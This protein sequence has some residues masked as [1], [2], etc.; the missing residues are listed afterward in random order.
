MA[1]RKFRWSKK[2]TLT[3]IGIA[4]IFLTLIIVL[5]FNLSAQEL[6]VSIIASNL[7]IVLIIIT[8]LT[9]QAKIDVKAIWGKKND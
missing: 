9:G 4:S 1:K 2:Y 7:S 8:Y 6:I 5:C 3:L